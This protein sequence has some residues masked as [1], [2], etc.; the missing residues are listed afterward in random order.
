M[1]CNKE[2]RGSVRSCFYSEC[3]AR[4]YRSCKFSHTIVNTD[5]ILDLG[6]SIDC[7]VTLDYG[8]GFERYGSYESWDS[9]WEVSVNGRS[10][11]SGGSIEK[12]Y[13]LPKS[14][15]LAESKLGIVAKGEAARQY[16][17]VQTLCVPHH[18]NLA[19][20]R[21][22]Y[23]YDHNLVESKRLERLAQTKWADEG[24]SNYDFLSVECRVRDGL[25]VWKIT[26]KPDA[27]TKLRPSDPLART[28]LPRPFSHEDE[29]LLNL[30]RHMEGLIGITET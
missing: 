15:L 23:R 30:V 24:V 9:G 22:D 10:L 6:R 8:S 18:R 13:N 20:R 12:V 29:D 28:I 27:F 2:L 11:K 19:C 17:K 7:V 25:A 14:L 5:R 1:I 3:E 21:P 16:P 4:F 26:T